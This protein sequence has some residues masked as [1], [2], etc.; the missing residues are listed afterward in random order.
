MD[1]RK[2]TDYFACM[3]SMDFPDPDFRT[4][5]DA[6]GKPE[7]FDEIR[8]S[9]V[10]LTEE[11]WVRQNVVRWITVRLGYPSF[12]IALEKE[13]YLG[14]MKKRFDLLVYDRDHK[15]WL[16]IECKAP[17]VPLTVATLM[18]GVGY[19]LALPVPYLMF[20]NGLQG[21]VAALSASGW[22]WLETMPAY[23]G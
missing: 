23:P 5:S 13:I 19:H 10:R 12:R 3:I 18:Q 20:T 11:E 4:R 2:N 15:P 16:L 22:V 9:W 1:L 6:A 14:D 8:R 21:A 7:I 17:S